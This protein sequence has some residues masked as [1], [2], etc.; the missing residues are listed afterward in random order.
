MEIT[1]EGLLKNNSSDMGTVV[2]TYIIE[3]SAGLIYDNEQLEQW[4]KHVEA[5][6]LV[7][8]TQIKQ[9]DKSPIPF[10]H[11]KSG[12]VKTFETLC[13]RKV[14]V[15]E[16]NAT[17]IPVEILDLVALSVNEGYFTKIQIWYD[18]KTPDPVCIGLKQ[19]LYAYIYDSPNKIG[20]YTKHDNL[21]V[22]EQNEFRKHPSLYFASDEIL[23]VY[24]LGKWADVKRSFSDLVKMAT[25]RYIQERSVEYQTKIKEAQRGL[26]DLEQEA[27]TRFGTN[28]NGND[29]DLDLPF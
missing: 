13:P 8:Q 24:L 25:Q 17:P 16:Y 22:E 11:L 26:D 29:L 21:T 6:G 5:L 12:L 9:K 28:V 14:D 4:N 2:E 1:M 20:S 18:D 23:G 3:E 10:M 15:K 27:F 19:N 7:G